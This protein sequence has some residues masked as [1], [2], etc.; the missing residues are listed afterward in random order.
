MKHDAAHLATRLAEHA[1]AVCQT[2]LSNGRRCGRYWIAGDVFNTKG[3]SLFVRLFGPASGRG[4]AGHWTDAA[5]AQ[6]GDLLDLIALNRGHTHLRDTLEE[7]RA[8]LGEPRRHAKPAP[9]AATRNSTN[10]ARKLFAAAQP[11]PGTLAQTYLCAR[12]ITGLTRLP[13]LRFHPACYYR[14]HE[15][16]PLETWPAL[17]AA[18]TDFSG[19][20]TGVH[21]TWLARDGTA[22]APV[23]DPRRALG[24]LLGNAV[25]FGAAGDVLAAGEGIETMLS[26]KSLLP[27]LPM[28]AALSAGHLGALL[29][30]PALR[31]LYIALDNDPAGH[32]AAARL[33]SRACEA[34]IE[35]H[36]LI[37]RGKDWNADLRT[38][39][40]AQLSRALQTQLLPADTTRFL[41]ST[42]SRAAP[43]KP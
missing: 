22:K 31:R 11:I 21:R 34:C 39:P 12:G 26:L 36:L 25:R 20:I 24:D 13:A 38:L 18:V 9:R 14:P 33:A 4:A 32:S 16:A 30:P 1:Q 5:T 19:N 43:A 7:A 23:A 28:A 35:A 17:I 10:A 8:F 42:D 29:L 3:R 40:L 27:H 41:N 2:Y 6:H 37:P 15:D